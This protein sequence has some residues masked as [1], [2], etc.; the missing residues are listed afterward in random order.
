[1]RVRKKYSTE[2]LDSYIHWKD[3]MFFNKDMTQIE[4]LPPT[5]Q[6]LEL[7]YQFG[8]VYTVKGFLSPVEFSF[9]NNFRVRYGMAAMMLSIRSIGTKLFAKAITSM[10]NSDPLP[11]DEEILEEVNNNRLT[12]I[13][14]DKDEQ[15][16][17]ER[18]YYYHLRRKYLRVFI[19][20]VCRLYR[21]RRV[22]PLIISI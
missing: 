13:V 21:H 11:D 3:W 20:I 9:F 5:L 8:L 12:E 19:G 2:L 4:I 10:L 6:N 17:I 1:M 22:H 7:M 18:E 16:I 14:S 15:R